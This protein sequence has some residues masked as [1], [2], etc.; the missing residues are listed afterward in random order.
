[1]S[2]LARNP[3]AIPDGV[4]IEVNGQ[5]VKAKGSKG[6]LCFTVHNDVGVA[7]E[8]GNVRVTPLKDTQQARALW[9]TMWSRIRNIIEGVHNGCEIQLEN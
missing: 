4:T 8:E 2:R 1:M 7:L 6:E 9:G 5:E 3:V